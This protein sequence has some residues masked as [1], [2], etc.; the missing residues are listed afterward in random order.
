MLNALIRFALKNRLIIVGLALGVI[1]CGSFVARD[2]SIDVLPDLTRPRVVIIAECPGMAPEEVETL[3]TLPIESAVNGANGV[4][5]VRSNSDIGLA[6]IYVEFDWDAD[7]YVARQIVQERL[8]TVAAEMPEGISPQIGPISSLLGQIMIVGMWSEDGST[9][10]LELRT[11]ADWSVRKRLLAIPGVSQVITMGG[12]RKQ[13]QVLVNPHEMH[14]YDVTLQD[15]EK[16][17]AS[18]NLNVTGGYLNDE[19]RELLVRGLGRVTNAADIETMVVKS[20]TARAVLVNDVARVVERGQV[21]RG[22]SSVNGHTAVVLTIQKQP[23]AD[24]REL[25][26]QIVAALDDMRPSFS[27]DVQLQATYVQREF[28][29]HSVY[30]V[31]EAVQV[32]AILVVVILFLFLLNFRTTFITLTAIP[33]SILTT[34]LVFRAFGLSINVMTLGGLA[35]ALG[36]LVDDAIVDVENIFRCLRENAQLTKPRAALKVIYEASREVRGAIVMSTIMVILVFA[37]LFGLSGMQG[38]MFQPLG[39]AYIVSILASTLVS[40][41]V[42]PVLSYFLL[43]KMG[44][45][46]APRKGIVARV[47]GIAF[48]PLSYLSKKFGNGKRSGDG[49]V[50]RMT[51]AIFS[52]LIRFSMSG[53][54]FALVAICSTLALAASIFISMNLGVDLIPK[55]DEGALQVNLFLPLGTS[56]DKSRQFGRMADKRLAK[57][58]ASKDNPNGPLRSHT[59]R[60]GRAELD[61]HVM[62]VNTTEYILSL[63]PDSGMSRAGLIKLVTDEMNQLPGVESEVEQPIAHLLSHMLSGVTAQIA[64]KLYGD[65]LDVLRRKAREIEGAI[66]DID[67]IADPVVDQQQIIP[68]LRIEMRRDKLAFYGISSEYVNRFVETAMNGR[69]VT[70]VLQDQRVFDVVVRLDDPFREDVVNLNR[71]PIELPDGGRVPLSAVARIYKGGGPNKISRENARRYIVVRVNTEERDLGSAVEEIRQR[72]A[73]EVK[74]PPGYFVEYQGQFEAQQQATRRILILSAIALAG[75]FVVLYSVFP[76]TNIVLQILVSIP[77]AFIGGVVAVMVTGQSVSVP[78]MVGFISLGGIAAR[79]GLLLTSTYAG[80][81]DELGFKKEMILH[82][83]LERLAPVLMTALTTGIGLVPLVIGG[84]LPGKEILFPVATVVVGGLI[85]CTFGEFLLRPGLFWFATNRDKFAAMVA[86]QED[87]QP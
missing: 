55:F 53:Q 69:N 74:L 63:N 56:L 23:T 75:V 79:N 27:K 8:A 57:L 51:R 58:V 76:S 41:T 43:S 10:D 20:G 7:I 6:V 83:S 44:A 62:G 64:V 25:T 3:V 22:D 37:P 86:A 2:L 67:G 70:K 49:I 15:I 31:I 78:T 14:R 65:D 81:H 47:M 38:R 60:T 5:A 36:E 33:L 48:A 82:G 9:S 61:E 72:V 50:L 87:E 4:E 39:V 71:T 80:L 68:Q 12:Q 35:V 24:T 59:A 28:I 77:I 17:L 52:P 30:N 46:P 29:D 21:K 34:A 42:T 1:V 18:G 32:G 26:D 66:E 54:G 45:D 40:L 73:S 19:S 13:Y 84:H 11:E 85:S 16:A